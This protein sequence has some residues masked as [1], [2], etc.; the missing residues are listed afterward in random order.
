MGIVPDLAAVRAVKRNAKLHAVSKR[1]EYAASVT[2]KENSSSQREKDEDERAL[3]NI[4][5]T[6]IRNLLETLGIV[7]SFLYFL[8]VLP[9]FCS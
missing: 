9:C 2:V 6:E 5:R 3:E 8:L 1:R 4:R 7:Y